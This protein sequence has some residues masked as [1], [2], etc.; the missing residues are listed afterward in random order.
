MTAT[1]VC[2]QPQ[3]SIHLPDSVKKIDVR[4]ISLKPIIVP[5]ESVRSCFF[6]SGSSISDD[7]MIEHAD[8]HHIQ[9]KKEQSV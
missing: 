6:L 8:Q 7:F 4:V 2:T 9:R 1:T 3:T 5:E